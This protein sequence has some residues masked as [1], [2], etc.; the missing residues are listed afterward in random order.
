MT[1]KQLTRRQVRWSELLSEFNFEIRYRPGKDGKKPE[2]LT[3]RPQDLPHSNDDP[4]LQFQN[5]TLLSQDLFKDINFDPANPEALHASSTEIVDGDEESTE[6]QI[7]R[8]LES[9][10]LLTPSS[11]E[12]QR[13]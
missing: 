4:R 8:L 3:R 9:S 11:S 10:I 12:S 5:R 1:A 2:S 7:T 13:R 6:L